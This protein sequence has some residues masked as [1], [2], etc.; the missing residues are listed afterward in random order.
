[1]DYICKEYCLYISGGLE[2]WGWVSVSLGSQL[3]L[4]CSCCYFSILCSRR[5]KDWK[6]VV[7]KEI[8]QIAGFHSN[9]SS[10]SIY[11]EHQKMF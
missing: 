10:D 5:M 3:Y 1:M 6:K 2:G 11:R 9:G 4:L 8:L 7:E